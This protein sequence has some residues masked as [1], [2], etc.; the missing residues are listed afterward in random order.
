MPTNVSDCP[1]VKDVCS[2]LARTFLEGYQ[3]RMLL[4][5]EDVYQNDCL[6]PPP[7]AYTDPRLKYNQEE[8]RKFVKKLQDAGMLDFTTRPVEFAGVF[9]VW[10]SDGWFIR[11]ILDARRANRL[12]Q[13]PPGVD[14]CTAES[15]SRIEVELP[16][17]VDPWDEEAQE[18]WQQTQVLSG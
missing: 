4:D 7:V 8:Y 5:A 2:P 3:E 12:F 11:L 10:K 9:F 16:E 15:F 13:D 14:M 6:K 1:F 17:G 18:L